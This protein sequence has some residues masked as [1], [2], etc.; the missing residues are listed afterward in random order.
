MM[1]GALPLSRVWHR[2]LQDTISNLDYA[3]WQPFSGALWHRNVIGGAKKQQL[4]V[5]ADSV[6]STLKSLVNSPTGP[7][8]GAGKA[9]AASVVALASIFG[10]TTAL[11]CLQGASI[12]HGLCAL[13]RPS[14]I[15]EVRRT[16]TCDLFARD[17]LGFV[18]CGV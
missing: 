9:A 15:A 6:L 14:L 18:A 17:G 4:P 11:P 1:V 8:G 3:A 5:S 7:S 13:R 12:L 2:G 16:C 10:A